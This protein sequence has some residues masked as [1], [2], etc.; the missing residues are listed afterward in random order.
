MEIGAV[1]LNREIG[2]NPIQSRCCKRES[3]FKMSLGISGKAKKMMNLSQKNC[4]FLITV[5]CDRQIGNAGARFCFVK[6]ALC[7]FLL[8]FNNRNM[9]FL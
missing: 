5:I 8:L 2:V 3:F 4:L 7:I 6:I 1:R 9:L